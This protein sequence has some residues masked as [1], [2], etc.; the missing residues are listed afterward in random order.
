MRA[1]HTTHF[2][3]FKEF[4]CC[5]FSKDDVCTM[6]CRKCMTCAAKCRCGTLYPVMAPKNKCWKVPEHEAF[7]ILDGMLFF[8]EYD[9]PIH[10]DTYEKCDTQEEWETFEMSKDLEI[11]DDHLHYNSGYLPFD[12][13]GFP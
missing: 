6:R 8:N 2:K 4:F 13:Y 10:E 12:T 5:A 1:T 9:F 11:M 3:K 7:A